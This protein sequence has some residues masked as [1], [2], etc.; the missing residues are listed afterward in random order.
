MT[1]WNQAKIWCRRHSGLIYG[2]AVLAVV[3]PGLWWCVGWPLRYQRLEPAA[4]QLPAETGIHAEAAEQEGKVTFTAVCVTDN[5]AVCELVQYVDYLA[6]GTW[7]QVL[8]WAGFFP[9]K[10]AEISWVGP[11]ELRPGESLVQT[12][13]LQALREEAE[14]KF[15]PTGRYR[16]RW[17]DAL[18]E[19]ELG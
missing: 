4:V 3:L 15:W 12:A 2:A 7:Y 13:D 1:V 10:G 14:K 18:Y 8:D 16:L 17:Y 9:A 5:H 19:F 11:N 6:D